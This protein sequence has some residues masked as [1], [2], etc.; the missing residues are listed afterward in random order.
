MTN[1]TCIFNVTGHPALSLPVGWSPAADDE[2]VMLPVGL[3]I[4]GG[5]W[6]EKKV[7]RIAKALEG[8]YDWQ[9]VE[10]PQA[11]DAGDVLTKVQPMEVSHL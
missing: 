4:V 3:Q 9:K 7:L 2:S 10:V 1:N 8:S 11:T 5:L 6:E